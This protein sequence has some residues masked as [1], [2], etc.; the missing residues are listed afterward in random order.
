[1][2]V[3]ADTSVWIEY[4]RQGERGWAAELDDL[5]ERGQVLMCG[6][7]LAEFLAG[8]PPERRSAFWVRLQALPW[9]ELERA[10]WLRVASV[11]GD[12]RRRGQVVAL[13]DIA[14]AVAAAAGSAAVWTAD[15]DFERVLEVMDD[16][17]L[18]YERRN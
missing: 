18:R 16:L 8:L 4:L 7:V 6:P 13:T 14:I 1:M 2:R 15:T 5:L 11:A 12:L 10:A 9:A 3:V 17:T